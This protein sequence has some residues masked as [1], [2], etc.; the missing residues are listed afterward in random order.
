MH[1]AFQQRVKLRHVTE[2]L[3][4]PLLPAERQAKGG[5]N[6]LEHLLIA[7]GDGKRP[8]RQQTL[9]NPG[10]IDDGTRIGGSNIGIAEILDAGLIKFVR[11]FA[12]LAEDF[13]EIGITFGCAGRRLDMAQA[14]GNGEFG[15]QAQALTRLA[16]RHED[17]AAQ[18]LA[19]H[20]Q[21][22]FRR[23]DDGRVH[24]TRAA[25]GEFFQ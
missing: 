5:N 23:L 3:Y 16:F 10:G 18:I 6:R 20:I 1:E 15:P 9:Q 21:K 19:S 12:A 11:T 4:Q 8:A 24:A 7:Q 14:D 25:R 17:T 13:T 2:G 22:R